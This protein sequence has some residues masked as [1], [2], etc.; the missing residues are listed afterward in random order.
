MNM[1]LLELILN[2]RRYLVIPK[3]EY[4]F[5]ST[6]H[7]RDWSIAGI[8]TFGC[9]PYFIDIVLSDKVEIDG[10]KFDIDSNDKLA[11]A[12]EFIKTRFCL[13]RMERGQS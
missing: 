2:E 7:N 13:A 6:P 11:M 5:M 1:K 8:K 4:L 3:T 12:Y 9:K 10:V